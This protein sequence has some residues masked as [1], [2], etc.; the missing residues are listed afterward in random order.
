[1]TKMATREITTSTAS[2]IL[3][4][5]SATGRGTSQVR[6]CLPCL[7]G[8]RT[9]RWTTL[10][11]RTRGSSCLMLLTGVDGWEGDHPLRGGNIIE[12]MSIGI[13]SEAG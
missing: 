11:H 2:S 10:D 7:L 12:V 5:L 13:D 9:G 3:A 1:M 6:L 8:P 4:V